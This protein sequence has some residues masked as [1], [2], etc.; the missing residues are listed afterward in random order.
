A[1]QLAPLLTAYPGNPRLHL[2]NCRLAVRRS[3]VK[4]PEAVAA[5]DR[6]ASLSADVGPA[7]EV[8]ELRRSYGDVAGARATIAPAEGRLTPLPADQAAASWARLARRYMDAEAVTWAEDAAAHAGDAARDVAAWVQ[9]TRIRFGIPRDAARYHL[10]PED[11][12]TALAAVR[13]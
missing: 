4:D 6:A 3:G 13:D 12:A 7:L 11:D 8:A 10:A 1:A 9:M 2:L 5:C